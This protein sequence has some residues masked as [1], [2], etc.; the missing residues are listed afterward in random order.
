MS[1][2]PTAEQQAV[3]DAVTAGRNL[4]VEAVAGAGKTATLRMAA[5]ANPGRRMLYVAYNKALAEEAKASMP[6]NVECRTAHSLA[7][8]DV[9]YRYKARLDAS[10]VSARDAL[11][12]MHGSGRPETRILNAPIDLGG[13][14]L[15]PITL[16]RLALATV[17]RYCQ[18]A[19][20][21]IATH[22][23][24]RVDGVKGLARQ[25]LADVVAPIAAL[26]WA[27][28]RHPAG[29]LRHTPDHYLKVWALT[30]PTLSAG[31]ILFDEAQ[32]ANPVLA[33]VL[34]AQQHAQQ[35]AVGD[36]CQQLY[37]WRGSVDALA[38]WPA[39]ERLY[40]SRSFR[41]GQAIADRANRWLDLLDAPTRVEGAPWLDS[42]VGPVDQPD[43]ILCR[44]NAG[45][46]RQTMEQLA[47]ARVYL[48]GGGTEV[49][50]LAEA[51]DQL[52]HGERCDHP[53]LAAFADWDEVRAYVAEDDS[54]SDLAPLVKLIDE[55]GTE[56][57]LATVAQLA[58]RP[59][60]ADV[61]VSTGHRSKGLQWPRV[62]IGDDY[63]EPVPTPYPTPDSPH[64]AM[65]LRRGEL[66][67]AYVG[68]TRAERRLDDSGLSWLDRLPAYGLPVL[69]VGEDGRPAG[70]PVVRPEPAPVEPKPADEV[71]EHHERVGARLLTLWCQRCQRPGQSHLDCTCR[72]MP[73]RELRMVVARV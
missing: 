31:T 14:V 28:L 66:M 58:Q 32:D 39:D 18:S 71:P 3:I 4:V 27:D 48:V 49:R 20:Q 23:L 67:L 70:T 13:V 64:K 24:P 6:S 29:R 5:H 2:K 35:I 52:M 26:A 68:V 57:I 56:E 73:D 17:D 69:V 30:R 50:R 37:A 65:V 12:I 34:T 1:H 10:R 61:V 53:E 40:L 43:A 9:G 38:T 8:R 15:R 36:S 63:R 7:Y 46:M 16:V 47:A 44:T 60:D 33:A 25:A 55:Y 22:H 59:E 11:T 54:G 51:A 41:F 62:T 72:L 21:D 19:D 42:T 45:A